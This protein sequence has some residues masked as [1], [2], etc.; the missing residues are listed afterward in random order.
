MNDTIHIRGL[1]LP[2]HIGVPEAERA[3]LQVVTADI[4]LTLDQG[5]ETMTDDL[6]AT[7]DYEAVTNE[8]KT[9]AAARPRQLI[10]TLAADLVE[11]LLKRS[12]ISAVEVEL[13]KRI[14]PGTDHVAVRMKRNREAQS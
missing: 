11:H 2:V 1:H 4:T 9:I 10:E 14:L 3:N 5:F 12:G 13:R 8:A 6:Q 7:I